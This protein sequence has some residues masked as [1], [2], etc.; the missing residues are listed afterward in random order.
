MSFT[1]TSLSLLSSSQDNQTAACD[2]KLRCVQYIRYLVCNSC[3]PF[4][5]RIDGYMLRMRMLLQIRRIRLQT[6]LDRLS[7]SDFS[8]KLLRQTK[9]MCF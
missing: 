5:P 8:T 7:S 6:I 9:W 1:K 4:N 2:D 3:R